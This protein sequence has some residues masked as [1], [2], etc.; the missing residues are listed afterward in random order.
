M[1]KP[2]VILLG[3]C[4][5]TSIFAQE[6]PADS[7]IYLPHEEL[8]V[9][10]DSIFEEGYKLFISEYASWYATDFYVEEKGSTDG[11]GGYVY[12]PNKYK[13]ATCV[14]FSKEDESEVVATVT[15]DSTLAFDNVSLDF[16]V[17]KATE[18]ELEYFALRQAAIA[19]LEEDTN[20]KFYNGTAPNLIPLID[21]KGRR[22]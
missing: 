13:G 14:L 15:F 2:L 1:T 20:Y 16:S 8:S 17:R 3:L 6:E 12:I 5:S 7:A 21:D 4:L 22:V 9:I 11:I 18:L 10:K 19:V